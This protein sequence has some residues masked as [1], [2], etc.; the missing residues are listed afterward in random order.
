MRIQ[1]KRPDTQIERRTTESA[2]TTAAQ[3][4]DYKGH[5]DIASARLID[6]L[7]R[8][9]RLADTRRPMRI[10]KFEGPEIEQGELIA[11]VVSTKGDIVVPTP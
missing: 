4:P 11:I 3:T 10:H 5:A 1:A 8:P 2:R 6:T 9:R 7:A